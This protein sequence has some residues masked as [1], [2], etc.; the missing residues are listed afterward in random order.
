MGAAVAGMVAGSKAVGQTDSLLLADDDKKSKHVCKAATPAR[1][2]AAAPAATTAAPARFLQGQGRLR[3][4][5][6]ALLQG[7]E[8]VQGPGRLRQRRQRLRGK[9]S[10]KGKGGCAVPLHGVE[11]KK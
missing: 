3:H 4:G 5:G 6:Q 10:C 2:K 7:P 1:G 8:R 11:K 9:N